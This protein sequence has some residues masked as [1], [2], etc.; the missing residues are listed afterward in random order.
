MDCPPTGWRIHVGVVNDLL[1]T[2]FLRMSQRPD[3]LVS[4]LRDRRI[5]RDESC[6]LWRWFVEVS[7]PYFEGV[8][9]GLSLEHG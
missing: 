4:G 5:G 1:V 8:I 7:D 9:A 2:V 3:C 6:G